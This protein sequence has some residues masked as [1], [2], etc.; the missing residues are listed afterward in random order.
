MP[1][2]AFAVQL[3]VAARDMLLPAHA[4]QVKVYGA[5]GRIKTPHHKALALQRN[6]FSA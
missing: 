2:A 1:D 6:A 5:A 4:A 3:G